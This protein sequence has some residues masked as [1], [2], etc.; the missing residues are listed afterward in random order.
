MKHIKKFYEKSEYSIEETPRQKDEREL[1]NFTKRLEYALNKYFDAKKN[2]ARKKSY[3]Y[4][5]C[6][7]GAKFPINFILHTGNLDTTK[8]D[9]VR[10]Y[11]ERTGV[12]HF[13]AY[14]L[15]REQAEDFLHEIK[16]NFI[17][18]D[19]NKYNL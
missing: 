14:D 4:I 3:N 8:V 1:K 12:R 13:I 9:K 16:T 7:L 19:M 6:C 5:S 15:T 18:E 11:F 2:D 10:K 17:E